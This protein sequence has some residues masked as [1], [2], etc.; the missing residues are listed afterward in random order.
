MCYDLVTAVDLLSEALQPE[1]PVRLP[2][3]V[4]RVPDLHGA[5]SV[6]I[7]GADVVLVEGLQV[8]GLDSSVTLPVL[9]RD[10]PVGPSVWPPVVVVEEVW[11]VQLSEDVSVVLLAAPLFPA[12]DSE[13][14]ALVH[15]G[16]ARRHKHHRSH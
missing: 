10:H 13:E 8:V 16:Q 7:L 5:H 4:R 1:A 6:Q 3:P 14:R 15:S 2:G 9:L 12:V 11:S